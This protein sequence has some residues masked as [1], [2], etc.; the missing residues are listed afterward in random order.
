MAIVKMAVQLAPE[1]E[2]EKRSPSFSMFAFR[3]VDAI[4]TLV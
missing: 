1:G 3:D 2:V 4:R